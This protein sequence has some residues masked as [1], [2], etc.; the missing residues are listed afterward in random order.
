MSHRRIELRVE[1]GALDDG[2]SWTLAAT[3]HLPDSPGSSAPVIVAMPGGGYTRHYFD[4]REHGYNQ[5]A[6]HVARGMV[7]VALDHLRVG[8]SDLPELEAASLAACA[9]A[10]HAVLRVIL[11][12]LRG[13]TL[14]D[15]L[16]GIEPVAV[17]GVG[18]SMGGHIG[19]LMQAAHKSFD[20]LAVLGSSVVSTRLP[21]RDQADA[22][23]LRGQDD[24]MTGL[25]ALVGFDFQYAFHWEDVPERFVAADMAGQ[26]GTGP[27]PYWRS[28]TTPNAG[29]GLLPGHLAGAAAVV[30]VPILIGMG[31]RDVCQDPLRE[32]AAFMGTSDLA[33]FVAPRMAHMHNFAGSR[34]LL[35]RRLDA[36]ATQI[37]DRAQPAVQM[38]G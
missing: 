21:A 28:A 20:G 6:H 17:I 14:A 7:V 19:L 10:N 22:V 2:Q 13:G 33:L 12:R 27:L 29:G 16:A 36:F 37:A 24:P 1:T 18:Q 31:E 9:A 25:S 32:L 15:D 8:E 4:L 38:N 26:R 3:V 35:W 30:T 34:E 23:C 5:A 11:E